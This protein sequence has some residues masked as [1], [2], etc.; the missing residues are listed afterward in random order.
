MDTVVLVG[1]L[2]SERDLYLL[3]RQHW[4]RIPLLKAPRRSYT[5]IA[6]YQPAIFGGQGKCIRYYARVRSHSIVRRD[7][8]LPDEADHPRAQFPYVRVRVGTI[9]RLPRPIRNIVPRRVTFGF[10]TLHRL[11]KANDMLQVYNVT[12]IE[13][14][15]GDAMTKA[16]IRAVAQ[17]TIVIGTHRF[18]LDFAVQC[19]RGWL[20]IE[21]DNK[22]SHTSLRDRARDRAKDRILRQNG[23][24]VLR[25]SERDIVSDLSGCIEFIKKVLSLRSRRGGR[26]HAFGRSPAG[27]QSRRF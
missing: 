15:V 17:H 23:W 9:Q 5:H 22:G 18:R 25:L 27:G 16:G 21:C 4:Y 13:Q 3:L 19:G 8:L 24:L 20:A 14:M 26:S 12:P 7:T 11:R 6:F 1:V 10:T 2:K